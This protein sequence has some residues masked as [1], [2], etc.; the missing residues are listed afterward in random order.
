MQKVMR[1][2]LY[3]E[4]EANCHLDMLPGRTGDYEGERNFGPI[5]QG[6][7]YFVVVANTDPSQPHNFAIR[8][9]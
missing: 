3:V 9:E 5:V 7:R 4:G 1:A 8:L 2:K 6:Q